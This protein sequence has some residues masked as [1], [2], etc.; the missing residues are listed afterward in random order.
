MRKSRQRSRYM[1]FA[2]F[3]FLKRKCYTS[4]VS[5]THKTSIPLQR[6]P[7][8]NSAALY[9]APVSE[10]PTRCKNSA[11][12]HTPLTPSHGRTGPAISL[13]RP[14]DLA[15]PDGGPNTVDLRRM[16]TFEH[17]FLGTGRGWCDYR[18][19]L[20]CS[21]TQCT[22]KRHIARANTHGGG[23]CLVKESCWPYSD[24]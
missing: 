7:L 14:R 1:R 15:K 8:P 10:H 11:I 3:A 5:L 20:D 16:P 18:K 9:W 21:Q 6:C 4:G 19:E 17:G 13:N 23:K 22:R 2:R 24:W 12:R